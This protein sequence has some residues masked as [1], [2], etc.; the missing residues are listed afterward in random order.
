MQFERLSLCTLV[1]NMLILCHEIRFF[2][3]KV[4]LI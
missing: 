3:N 2:G 1:N 4:D